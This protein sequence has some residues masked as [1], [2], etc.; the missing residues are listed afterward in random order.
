MNPELTQFEKS[1][2]K[3]HSIAWTPKYEESFQTQVSKTVFVPIACEVF[4]ELG[5]EFAFRGE[6]D[7]GARTTNDFGTYSEWVTVSYD[8]GQVQVKS[9][10]QRG[11]W[12]NG[13]NSKRVKLFIHAFEQKVKSMDREA[14]KALEEE[15]ERVENWDDYEIPK[16]LPPPPVNRVTR[17]WIPVLGGIVIALIL[18]FCLAF[19]TVNLSYIF[20]VFEVAVGFAIGFAFKYLIRWSNV[21][22]FKKLRNFLIGTVI[23]TS[24]AISSSRCSTREVLRFSSNS[25]LISSLREASALTVT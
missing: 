19:L 8:F 17:P 3:K 2:K 9:K 11:M 14:L 10:S 24:L 6:N 12:D 20:I 18:G 16:E 21:T 23:L 5:W 22:D 15:V 4:E 25:F 1:I 13:R 7:A